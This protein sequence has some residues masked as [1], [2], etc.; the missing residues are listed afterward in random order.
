MI[1]GLHSPATTGFP[2]AIRVQEQPRSTLGPVVG[3]TGV[4][5]EGM[6]QSPVGSKE[7]LRPDGVHAHASVMSMHEDVIFSSGPVAMHVGDVIHDPSPMQNHVQATV[8]LGNL[9]DNVIGAV[10]DGMDQPMENELGLG[11]QMLNATK[12]TANRPTPSRF[13]GDSMHQFVVD[14]DAHKPPPPPPVVETVVVE[15]AKVAPPIATKKGKGIVEDGFIEVVK[16]K[17]K[18]N[19]P[20]PRVLIPSL[21][22]SKPSTSKPSGR[23]RPSVVVGP[24]TK[25]QN[26]HVHVSNP[27]SALDDTTHT[28]DH[29]PELNA[30]LKK[31]AKRY[32]DTNTIPQPDVLATWSTDL[33]DYYYSLTKEDVEEVESETDGTARL[34]S[35]DVP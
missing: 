21:S 33:K 11:V 17:K 10:Q 5:S 20:K 27:F 35:K 12:P 3:V 14:E 7:H 31:F 4:Q 8:V 19:G 1:L 23:T 9:D 18:S 34:M 25:A 15:P 16:K 28:D 6:E 29:F 13:S 30:T 2:Q 22:V 24:S 26:A 32:V